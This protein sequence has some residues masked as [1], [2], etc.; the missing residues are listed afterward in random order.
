M[1]MWLR[2]TTSKMRRQSR[3]PKLVVSSETAKA[4]AQV[5]TVR[6]EQTAPVKESN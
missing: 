2:N 4:P 1:G 5:P 6:D 3:R